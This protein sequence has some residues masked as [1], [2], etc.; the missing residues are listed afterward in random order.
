[1]RLRH[2][3]QSYRQLAECGP[4]RWG[5]AKSV[6]TA[7]LLW[8]AS[9]LCSAGF[10][11]AASDLAE[12]VASPPVRQ[13]LE[14]IRAR[15]QDTAGR[16]V[17]IGG[18][19]APSGDE[20]ERAA[21]VAD[22]MREIGLAGVEVTPVSNVLGRIPGHSG[23]A[24]VFVST[25]DDLATVAEHQR[26]RGRPPEIKGD[27]VVGPGANTSLTTAALLSAAQAVLA[28]DLAPR[29]DIV[30]AAVAREETGLEGMKA[31][32]DNYRDR[33]LAFVDVLGE[34]EVLQ[35]GGIGIHWWKVV[36][37]GQG[38]HTLE[39]GVPNINHGIAR[40]VD[41][42]LELA[43]PDKGAD[44]TA[45]LNIAVL[46]SGSVYNHKPEAGWF[47]LDVRALDTGE[48]AALE[49]QVDEVLDQVTRESGVGFTRE[50]VTAIPPGQIP[51]AKDSALV[52][53]SLAISRH[54]GTEPRLSNTGSSNMNIAVAG[55][56]PAIQ[57]GSER[58]GRRGYPD[59]WADIETLQ[60][61]A[62]HVFLLAVALAGMEG[63][64]LKESPSAS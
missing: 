52:R 42:I 9:P 55:G 20:G 34:G 26:A 40:A 37:R 43:P 7:C 30:F 8:L 1:M 36:A 44:T 4:I 46:D 17:R 59:E 51:G 61:T 60:R 57:I 53:Y 48:M 38:G 14:D 21:A 31:L 15:R 22:M 32:Y 19:A 24:I 11:G 39:P 41:R 3:P 10:A 28:S 54:L 29:H 47:S 16:L 35:Y 63:E 23:K 58:G 33:A 13:G 5:L 18:I 49:Q 62:S 12:L 56:T 45:W 6:A 27:R 2:H 50:A 25:L 64:G